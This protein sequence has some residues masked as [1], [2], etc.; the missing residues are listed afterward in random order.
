MNR[1]IQ[2]TYA[3][4]VRRLKC[5]ARRMPRTRSRSRG[6]GE[7]TVAPTSTSREAYAIAAEAFDSQLAALR[8]LVETDLRALEGAMEKAG[9]PWTPGRVPAWTRE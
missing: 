7:T 8:K 4:S 9:A 5:R 2:P 6:S 3:S 1:R